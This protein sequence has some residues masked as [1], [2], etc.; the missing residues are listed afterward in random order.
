MTKVS[1]II[2]VYNAERTL[3]RCLEAI[4]KQTYKDFEAICV[5]D[6]S[7]DNSF[8]ILQKYSKLDS[9]IKIFN[10]EN[11]G[12][13]KTRNF[14]ISKACGEYLMFCDAD[15][16]YEP[17][18]VKK[19]VETIESKNVD[20]VMCNC[21]IHN[22]SNTSIIPK[23][24][25]QYCHIKIKEKMDVNID[26]FDKINVLLW[27]KIFKKE[28]LD[29][30]N[31]SYPTKYEHDDDNF[32]VKYLLF[33][34]SY[35]GIEDKLYNY[36]VGNPHSIM[37]KYYTKTNNNSYFDFIYNQID[38]YSWIKTNLDTNASYKYLN[39]FKNKY[40]NFYTK[41]NEENKCK[42]IEL[43][44]N[45]ITNNPEVKS[46]KFFKKI[47]SIPLKKY[48]KID[49][50]ITEDVTFIQKIFSLRNRENYKILYFLGRKFQINRNAKFYYENNYDLKPFFEQNN[51]PV[52]FA[53]NKS[54]AKYLSVTIA[55][56]LNNS[57]K[58]HNYDI[59]ILHNDIDKDLQEKFFKIIEHHK[60]INIRFFDVSLLIKQFQ[61]DKWYVKHLNISAYYRILSP[62]IFKNFKKIIYLDSDVIINANLS[63]LYEITLDDKAI[64]AIRDEF[65]SKINSDNNYSFPFFQ[66]YA[67][68]ILKLKSLK[69]YFNSGVMV[70]DIEHINKCNY[71]EKFLKLGRLNNKYFHDQNILNSVLQNDVKLIDNAWNLQ[72]STNHKNDTIKHGKILHYC[73]AKKPWLTLSNSIQ[74]KIWLENAKKSPL[75]SEV[76][77]KAEIIVSLTTFP[78][79]VNVVHLTIN[80]ILQQTLKPDKITLV[81]SK[82]EFPNLEKDLPGTLLKLVNEKQI[83]ID[84]VNNNTKPYKKLIPTLE[85]NK[86]AIIITVDDDVIYDINLVKK[87]YETYQENPKCVIATRGHR[88]KLNHNKICR[89]NEWEYET[90]SKEASFNIFATGIGGVLYPPKVL[91][92]DI[93][94]ENL[95]LKLCETNDDVWFWAMAVL[96]HTKIKL[97]EKVELRN[98]EGTQEQALFHENVINGNNDIYMKN[99]IKNYP[100]ILKL[101]TS[102]EKFSFNQIFQT[103]FSIKNEYKNEKKY[104]KITILG[105]NFKISKKQIGKSELSKSNHI[106][107]IACY[108]KPAILLK[109]EIY[110][111]IHAGRALRYL[112]HKDGKTSKQNFKWL[113][114]NMIG[115]DTGDNI[116]NLN[117]EL[118]EMTAIYWV[119]KNYNKIGSPKYIGFNHYRRFWNIPSKLHNNRVTFD[120]DKLR[121]ILSDCDILCNTFT[122]IPASLKNDYASHSDWG[123]KME[124][125]DKTLEILKNRNYI[126]IHNILTKPSS[127]PMYNCFIMKKEIFFNYC[128]WLFPILF[129][130]KDYFKD[131]KYKPNTQEN[132]NLSWM[133][134]RLTYSYI[135]LLQKKYKI[136]Q[137][138]IVNIDTDI[139]VKN[140]L[141]KKQFLK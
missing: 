60:N 16:W 137:H 114:D 88:I 131:Y 59:I 69:N 71:F 49:K 12:P 78:A 76:T 42:A 102:K 101:L 80:S 20:L 105:I 18:M 72:L 82:L 127:G 52:I 46:S 96:N 86:E 139:E 41:L 94:K 99:I 138:P 125:F 134:E 51:I 64:L 11:S 112:N 48:N 68:K 121:S 10:Q 9:R 74:D 70:M 126:D 38:I 32:I 104:K 132:R 109:D 33:I 21:N 98:I 133:A 136:K 43:L 56:L 124:F 31:I 119:W 61:I 25:C 50:F 67:R 92:S 2:P 87:L 7:K 36:I 103:I 23:D 117:R 129:E 17:L 79:R 113:L 13:A 63:E 135:N 5:N 57:D 93:L 30:N 108:H 100:E 111:P 27:N 107:I 62:L 128:E 54:F 89:Y 118:N 44:K 106:K 55:S 85:K 120:L 8:Q 53:C 1:I 26:N 4:L 66:T 81:L 141:F 97:T 90:N 115:D 95:F 84:W 45:F 35:Y 73:S 24:Y 14:A 83:S 34:K 39:I 65:I 75:Y 47:S 28:I 140:S 15:D 130:L 77:K 22:L 110:T 37:G 40:I 91:H 3:P 58:N 19:M 122:D 6:G 123:M 29:K 116:S